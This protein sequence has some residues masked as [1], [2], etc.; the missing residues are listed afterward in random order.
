MEASK[1]CKWDLGVFLCE[2]DYESH[3]T[4]IPKNSCSESI[5]DK[6]SKYH[7]HFEIGIAGHL[8]EETIS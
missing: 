1:G 3:L 7:S 8:G 6:V 4:S 5:P 2:A